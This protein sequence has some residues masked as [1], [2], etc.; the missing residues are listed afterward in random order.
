ML[1][2]L[3]KNTVES[4]L[5]DLQNFLQRILTIITLA[6]HVIDGIL[7]VRIGEPHQIPQTRQKPPSAALP[8]SCRL[9]QRQSVHRAMASLSH[10]KELL[11]E[12]T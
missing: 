3:S 1:S 7:G 10:E 9:Y 12:A 6:D 5:I 2:M 11:F 4:Y 8:N